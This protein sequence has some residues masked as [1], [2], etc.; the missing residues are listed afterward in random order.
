MAMDERES[1]NVRIVLLDL[2]FA[3]Q[4]RR[5]S[6]RGGVVCACGRFAVTQ[7]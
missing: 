1:R 2:R 5:V 3:M 6:A 4:S 7:K